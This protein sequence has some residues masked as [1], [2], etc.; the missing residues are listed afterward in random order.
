[1]FTPAVTDTAADTNT[2]A[3]VTSLYKHHV[4]GRARFYY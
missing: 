4:G 1:M 2:D 3:A